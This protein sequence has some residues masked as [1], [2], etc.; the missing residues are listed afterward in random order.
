MPTS[1][2]CRDADM[3]AIST[4]HLVKRCQVTPY[5]SAPRDNVGF[6]FCKNRTRWLGGA[7]NIEKVVY[8]AKYLVQNILQQRINHFTHGNVH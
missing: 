2:N 6:P 8:L 5:T 7:G 3:L 1:Y 4:K